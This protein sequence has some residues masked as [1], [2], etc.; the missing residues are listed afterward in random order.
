MEKKTLQDVK[1]REVYVANDGKEFSYEDACVWYETPDVIKNKIEH[2]RKIED[3]DENYYSVYYIESLEEYKYLKAYYNRNYHRAFCDAKNIY[4]SKFPQYIVVNEDASGD[5]MSY[6][7]KTLEEIKEQIA[8]DMHK[9]LEF[10][11]QL[12]FIVE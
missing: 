10:K 12:E 7:P 9:I 2:P 1:S 4:F 3:Y 5:Y 6:V 11:E 8:S